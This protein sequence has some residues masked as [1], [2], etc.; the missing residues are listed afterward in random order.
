MR[1][2]E[3]GREVENEEYP[4]DGGSIDRVILSLLASMTKRE[5]V[6]VFPLMSNMKSNVPIHVL[7]VMVNLTLMLL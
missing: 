6:D 3:R 4:N 2:A 7:K 1:E 5:I